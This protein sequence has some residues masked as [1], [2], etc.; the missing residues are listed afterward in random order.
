MMFTGI[1]KKIWGLKRLQ[2]YFPVLSGM[3]APV[4]T[5]S[6]FWEEEVGVDFSSRGLPLLQFEQLQQ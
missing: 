6:S 4:L 5:V 2:W 1:V 3:I